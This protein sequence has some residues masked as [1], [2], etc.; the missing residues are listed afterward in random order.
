[1]TTLLSH[2]DSSPVRMVK[3][4]EKTPDLL[5]VMWESVRAAAASEGNPPK[6]LNRVL[7]TA[8]HYA[9]HFCLNDKM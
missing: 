8:R 6:W 7:D 5:A 2:P 4:V 3:I 9:S 1:M